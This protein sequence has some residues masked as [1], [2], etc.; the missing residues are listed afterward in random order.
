VILFQKQEGEPERHGEKDMWIKE[1]VVGGEGAGC[2][3]L[4]WYYAL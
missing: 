3:L 1:I 4:P 2:Y